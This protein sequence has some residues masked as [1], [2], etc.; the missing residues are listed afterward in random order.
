MI[1]FKQNIN[2]DELIKESKRIS[3]EIDKAI[4][5]TLPPRSSIK[6]LNNTPQ[7][8][9][10]VGCPNLPILFSQ[11]HVRNCMHPKGKNPHWH[12]LQKSTLENLPLLLSEPTIIYDS[13]TNEDSI[14]LVL[15]EL[16]EDRLPIIAS[17]TP[18]GS[19]QY[20][21]EKLNSNYLTSVYGKENLTTVLE[22]ADEADFILYVDK[23]KSQELCNLARLQLP[24]GLH[25]PD[26]DIILHKSS[27]FVNEN[28][29]EITQFSYD[30]N[31]LQKTGRIINNP[32]MMIS[33]EEIDVLKEAGLF[34]QI[35]SP[36]LTAAEQEEIYNIHKNDKRFS[37]GYIIG[38]NIVGR[39]MSI[40]SIQRGTDDLKIYETNYTKGAGT[41]Y[42][43]TMPRR[44]SEP[45]EILNH[46]KTY[47]YRLSNDGKELKEA[48][49]KDVISEKATPLSICDKLAE[50]HSELGQQDISDKEKTVPEHEDHL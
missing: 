34:S 10:D 3:G 2:R 6:I 50:K 7:I 48:E 16:A 26:F 17:L 13:L 36:N 24:Y 4:N 19:G 21:F 45:E 23:E 12:G 33:E 31:L 29:S 11:S 20:Q 39:N 28:P 27:N 40:T 1:Y 42:K 9:L 32:N 25:Q 41:S 47:G 18:N 43:K 46:L 14:V 15:N 8:L 44:I 38:W 22:K 5:Y 35:T 49:C 37:T 30:Y